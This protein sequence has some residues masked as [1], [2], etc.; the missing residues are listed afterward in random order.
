[1]LYDSLPHRFPFLMVD[2]IISVSDGKASGIKQI[3]QEYFTREGY[4]PQVILIEAL[5]QISGVAGGI[6]GQSLFAGIKDIVFHKHVLCGDVLYLESK[7]NRKIGS[8]VE[9][10]VT[11]FVDKDSVI[12][13]TL[14]LS[15]ND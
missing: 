10:T 9:F 4:F 3:T 11:A 7:V 6:K 15:I 8:I 5:A 13:G 14:Y 2:R 1:M 12:S